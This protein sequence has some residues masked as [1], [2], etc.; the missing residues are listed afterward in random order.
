[1]LVF[2]DSIQCNDNEDSFCLCEVNGDSVKVPIPPP[3]PSHHGAGSRDFLFGLTGLLIGWA[4]GSGAM[5]LYRCYKGGYCGQAASCCRGNGV[6][7]RGGGEAG[8]IRRP[9]R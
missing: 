2:H 4:L 3:S 1:M 9:P 7:S 5:G 6:D 8:G